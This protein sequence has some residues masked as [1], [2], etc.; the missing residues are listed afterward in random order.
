MLR[1]LQWLQVN[2]LTRNVDLTASYGGGTCVLAGHDGRGYIM[3][4]ASCDVAGMAMAVCQC[5]KP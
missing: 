4:S 2:Q 5:P 3:R 1:T